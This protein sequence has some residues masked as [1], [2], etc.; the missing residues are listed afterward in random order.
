MRKEKNMGIEL[1][2]IISMFMVIFLHILNFGI[3]YQG[4][5]SFS[6]NWYI[7]WFLEGFCYCAVNIYAMISGY[8]M[9]NSRCR[10]SRIIELWLQVF[11]YS[12]ISILVLNK[13]QPELVSRMDI[14]KSCFPVLSQ[15]FWYF[16]A[17]FA[18]FWF[19]PFFNWIVDK[20]SYIQM[21]KLIYRLILIFG[22]MP[23][24]AELW[25]TWAFW[26]NRRI[27]STLAFNYVFSGSRD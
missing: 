26:I 23:W 13:L 7:S 20:L 6:A 3:N 2:R 8:V 11:C 12:I 27:Y 17:Y 24:I 15:R 25:G 10:A 22:I 14:W 1:L 5:E 9:L 21:R 18:I 4:L 16:T 19:I